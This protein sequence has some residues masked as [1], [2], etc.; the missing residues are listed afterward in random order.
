MRLFKYDGSPNDGD[1]GS[2]SKSGNLN[3]DSQVEAWIGNT[4]G[5]AA[6]HDGHIDEV[7]ISAAARSTAWLK[8][9]YESQKDNSTFLRME[10]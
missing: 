9:C 7:R 4:Q 1:V 2:A 8:L 3:T 10:N 6:N 5:N